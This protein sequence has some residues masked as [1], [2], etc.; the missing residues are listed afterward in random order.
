MKNDCPTKLL[1][2]IP[3]KDDELDSHWK[4]ADAIK[5]LIESEEGGKAIAIKGD[6]GSGK[7]SIIK[8]LNK[9]TRSKNIEVFEYD[10]W[11]HEGDPLRRAFLE[12]LIR[13]LIN[14]QLVEEDKWKKRIEELNLK[15]KEEF[16]DKTPQITNIGMIF[17]VLTLFIPVGIALVNNFHPAFSPEWFYLGLVLAASPL[18]LLLLI[19][20]WNF[21]NEK[22][23][24]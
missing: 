9:N 2:D 18:I 23:R 24:K 22:K 4:I 16:I 8:M 14:K 10:N 15:V 11:S 5:N 12:E 19:L 13:F 20:L 6:W 1:E 17:T 7:S 3:T 21:A